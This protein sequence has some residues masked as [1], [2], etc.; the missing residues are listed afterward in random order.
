MTSA[1]PGVPPRKY[2][3]LEIFKNPMKRQITSAGK[4]GNRTP[5]MKFQKKHT[6]N[7]VDR[8]SIRI[9]SANSRIRPSSQAGSVTFKDDNNKTINKDRSDTDT[10]QEK[11]GGPTA[12]WIQ[13]STAR[14]DK[15][16]KQ[17]IF[18]F[19]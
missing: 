15:T 13:N 7:S 6:S 12:Q 17:K 18:Q 8:N 5:I 2:N 3:V 9:T 11:V 14:G 10:D 19:L 1:V 4:P 16:S